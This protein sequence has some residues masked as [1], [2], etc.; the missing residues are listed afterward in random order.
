MSGEGE[1]A[2][3]ASVSA[4]RR[5]R[6]LLAAALATGASG[7]LGLTLAGAQ[8]AQTLDPSGRPPFVPSAGDWEGHVG[9]LHASFTLVPATSDAVGAGASAY[10][11]ADLVIQ[12][13][14]GCPVSTSSARDASFLVFP[15]TP[16]L[17]I[18][19]DG[20][21]PFAA[22]PL[23]GWLSA[24]GR[25]VTLA[26]FG[27][28]RKNPHCTGTLR[29]SMAPAQ[30]QTVDDGTWM[31]TGAADAGATFTVTAA[32]RVVSGLPIAAAVPACPDGSG[33]PFT[34]MATMFVKAGGKAA[35]S[36]TGPN[37]K[38]HIALAFSGADSVQGSFTATKKGCMPGVMDFTA[39]L[40]S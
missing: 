36:L 14:S 32:G 35:E 22:T 17:A 28:G 3:E 7:T 24:A 18:A 29:F 2:S 23:R 13:P 11:V 16:A 38:L 26:P 1:I 12:V 33:T 20:T 21:F 40:S 19:P 4:G 30:R 31:V 25:A 27:K 39:R 8:S 34:G 10:A 37:G 15:D 5:R 6:V 9:A